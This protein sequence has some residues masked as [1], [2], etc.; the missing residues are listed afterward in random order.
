MGKFGINT[1]ASVFTGD[2][3]DLSGKTTTQAYLT[4]TFKFIHKKIGEISLVVPYAY[5]NG[6]GVTAGE[7][8]LISTQSVPKRADGIGDISLK[9]RY[10][11]FEGNDLL[12]IVDL[13]AKVKF[14]TASAE[15]GIG[16]GKYDFG[17]GSSLL[18]QFGKFVGLLDTDLIMRQRPNNSSI[19]AAA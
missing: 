18:K 16:T 13:T 10:C 1:Q 4:E 17:V 11:W 8:T 5:R 6:G 2:F 7:S 14:P 3:G 12:P 9:G 19:T 15:R